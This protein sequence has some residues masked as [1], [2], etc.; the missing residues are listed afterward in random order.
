MKKE[1]IP[2][3]WQGATNYSKETPEFDGI[4]MFD[5]SIKNYL[6]LGTSIIHHKLAYD[7]CNR[8]PYQSRRGKYLLLLVNE[9]NIIVHYVFSNCKRKELG[10][11]IS[12]LF[13]F[14]VIFCYWKTYARRYV[15][16]RFYVMNKEFPFSSKI[17]VER[18][19]EYCWDCE[20][21]HQYQQ[22]LN[23][24]IRTMIQYLKTLNWTD[25]QIKFALYE[26]WKGLT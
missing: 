10:K 16:C 1:A 21:K 8:S 22:T 23:Q 19:L 18:D 13:G 26:G 2:T 15:L 14:K 11:Q 12:Q 17:R 6:G 7:V 25:Q 20:K 24:Y 4:V 9:Q 5:Q 3:E